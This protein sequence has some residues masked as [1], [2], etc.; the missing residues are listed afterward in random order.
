MIARKYYSKQG[1]T[2][3]SGQ[4]IEAEID[5][6]KSTRDEIIDA[7]LEKN[8]KDYIFPETAQIGK[9]EPQIVS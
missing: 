1:R 7:Y 2:I 5:K 3:F 4:Q 8:G 6:L 9:V